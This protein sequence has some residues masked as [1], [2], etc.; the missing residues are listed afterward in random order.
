[1]SRS[2]IYAIDLN[3]LLALQVL[4]EE[5]SVTRAAARFGLTQSAMRRN[6]AK[7]REQ[8]DDPLLVRTRHGMRPTPRAAALRDPLRRLVADATAI[9]DLHVEFDPSTSKRAFV[10]SAS[11]YVE[12]VLL[13]PLLEELGRVAP[14]ID[15]AARTINRYVADNLEDGQID[16]AV[17]PIWGMDH[18]GL[19][20]QKLHQEDFRCVVRPDHPVASSEL[21]LDRYCDLS[22]A[23]AAPLE[24]PGGIVDAA[25]A[26]LDRKRRVALTVPSFLVVG[27]AVARSDLIATLPRRIAEHFAETLGLISMEPP[28]DVPSFSVSQFWHERRQRDPAHVWFRGV[29][30][31]LLGD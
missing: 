29:I 1:M 14:G 18:P 31:S 26:R 4:L 3:L 16:L 30:R 20:K 21:D 9:V 19:R 6:L 22:H 25:L 10:L 12:A 17:G 23:L 11:D 28:L 13:P 5:N 2:N 24:Q 15:I 8:L 7:L 27:H